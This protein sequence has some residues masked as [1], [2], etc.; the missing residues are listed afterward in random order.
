MN[1]NQNQIKFRL[2]THDNHDQIRIGKAS[3]IPECCLDV[4]IKGLIEEY[5]KEQQWCGGFKGA[6]EAYYQRMAIVDADT[7]QD[8]KVLYPEP[9]KEEQ[10]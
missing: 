10:S 1:Q 8:I 7:L 4:F 5:D 9:E 2:L 3:I 6:C